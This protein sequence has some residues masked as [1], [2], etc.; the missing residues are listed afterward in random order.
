L[1]PL[2]DDLGRLVV[3]H[4]VDHARPVV[5]DDHIQIGLDM[6]TLGSEAERRLA[7]LEVDPVL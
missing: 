2:R 3:S 5:L 6:V 7:D 1:K 4:R